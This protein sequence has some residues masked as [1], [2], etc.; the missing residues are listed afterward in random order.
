MRKVVVSIFIISAVLLL[1][2]EVRSQVTIKN[3]SVLNEQGHVEISWEY[4]GL[5]NLIISR[6]SLNINNLSPIHVITNPADTSYTDT[7]AQAH[8]TPRAYQIQSETNTSVLSDLVYTY[9]L[10]FNY[11]SCA[12]QINLNWEKLESDILKYDWKPALFTIRINEGGN[13]RAEQ[14]NTSHTDYSVQG[15]LENINYSIYL[16]TKWEGLDAISR[17]NPINKFT[18]MPQSPDTIE[19]ISTIADGNNTNLKFEIASNSELDTYKL[20]KS[21][22]PSGFFDT[23]E[24]F[25][26]TNNQLLATDYNSQPENN[27]RYYKL[28]SVNSCGNET[29][30]SDIINNIVLEVSN[31]E[32]TNK[33]TWNSFKE[34]NLT[35]AN[36]DI[37]RIIN[38]QEPELIRSFSNFNTFKDN[39]ETLQDYSQFCYFI[40]ATEEG[41]LEDNYSQS[42][43]ACAYLTPKVYLP[44][45]FTPNDD[46]INDLFQP[47]FTFIP[48]EYNLKIYNRWGNVT[49]ET[50]DYSQAWNGKDHNGNS[51]PTGVYIYY[52]RIESPNNQI[53]ER[54]GNITILYP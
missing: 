39:I 15:V 54:R 18:L 9:F 31:E 22:S 25:I 21:D 8:I 3:V 51:I 44:E 12:Q 40:R 2:I 23:L 33:L 47:V 30:H 28:V 13:L 5:D 46:G 45:V 7:T 14:T 20:L 27:I 53:I 11:D 16:E 50:T 35:P 10:T 43:I 48:K 41:A 19:A 42:N 1:N 34:D 24:T 37:Y 29:T 36:Y 52:L 17:S 49:F 38:N 32:Y 6:D 26:N 4:N